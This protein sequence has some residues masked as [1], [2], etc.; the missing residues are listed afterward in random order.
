M[1]LAAC[2]SVSGLETQ[3]RILASPPCTD[4]FFPVYFAGGSAELGAAAGRVI[5][6]AGQ[7]AQGCQGPKVEVVGLPDPGAG[8]AGL[9]R[10]RA[11]RLAEALQ[12]SG[13][14]APVFQADALGGAARPAPERRR[15]DVYIRFQH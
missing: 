4:F 8:G 2:G 11:R 7:Q 10:E 5:R 3:A 9:P 15:V 1:G 13:L 12:G 14:P 6:N